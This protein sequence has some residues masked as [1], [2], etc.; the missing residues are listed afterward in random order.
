MASEYVLV[1]YTLQTQNLIPVIHKNI[2]GKTV[3]SSQYS[4]PVVWPQDH[5]FFLYIPFQCF[6]YLVKS[7]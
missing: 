2:S 7:I 5:K 4:A 1:L 3:F 6:E